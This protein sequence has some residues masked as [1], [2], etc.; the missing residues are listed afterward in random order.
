MGHQAL[1]PLVNNVALLLALGVAYDTLVLQRRAYT[2][3]RQLLFGFILGMV[4]L[5]VMHNSWQ[6]APGILF[7]TRSIVIS[8]SGLFLGLVPTLVAWAM[9][10]LYRLHEG[11]HGAVM[12]VAV[13]TTSAAIGLLWRRWRAG[14][15]GT[16]RAAELYLFG[17][18][19]H[20][21]MLPCTVLLP[22]SIAGDVLRTITLPVLLFYPPGTV[23]P[24]HAAGAAGGAQPRARGARG[25]RDA[26]PQPV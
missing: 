23:A 15:P 10:V 12:G 24:G 20:L 11:G 9:T 1:V 26:L 21:V 22:W 7:D 6:F 4:G 8:I 16:M 25:E 2:L 13:M 17:L 3:R 18:L 14:R 19:V 5:A